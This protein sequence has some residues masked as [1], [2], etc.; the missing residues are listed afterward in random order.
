MLSA[1]AFLLG[2]VYYTMFPY[3]RDHLADP[4]YYESFLSGTSIFAL[5][6]AFLPSPNLLGKTT[7]PESNP[8]DST[9]AAATS[10]TAAVNGNKKG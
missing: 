2:V 10:E 1:L 9:D 8:D 4:A 6:A 7:E 5:S 3:V